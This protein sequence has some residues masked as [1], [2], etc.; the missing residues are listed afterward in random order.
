MPDASDKSSGFFSVEPSGVT[1]FRP[2]RLISSIPEDQL[3]CSAASVFT[4]ID[5]LMSRHHARR[6]RRVLH[7]TY[8]EMAHDTPAFLA[9]RGVSD[10]ALNHLCGL[11]YDNGHYYAW[12]PSPEMHPNPGLLVFLHGNAGN[13]KLFCHRWQ[14]VAETLGLVILAPT[15]G[16]GFWGKNSANVIGRSI[17]D[18]LARWPQINPARGLWLMGLSDGGNGVTR[19]AL[20]QPWHGLIYLSATMRAKELSAQPWI[21][22]WQGRP[23]MVLHGRTD[24]NVSPRMV[25]KSLEALKRSAVELDENWYDKEDHF[26]CFGA[27]DAV[28]ERIFRWIR[29]HQPTTPANDH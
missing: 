20:A 17:D 15:C 22:S 16:F 23:V 25:E 13:L 3:V 21:D 1:I 14:K 6:V 28:D 18:A 11:P 24:H 26:L 9:S 4:R 27:A 10:L 19:A 8:A 7:S 2:F 5:L 29:A 12:L